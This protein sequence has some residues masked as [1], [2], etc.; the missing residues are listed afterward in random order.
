MDDFAFLDRTRHPKNVTLCNH[1]ETSLPPEGTIYCFAIQDRVTES[2]FH[3]QINAF[4]TLNI[5]RRHKD[6][7]EWIPRKEGFMS[8]SFLQVPE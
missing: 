5:G 6:K 1:K 7:W 8:F 2:V 4:R 3:L